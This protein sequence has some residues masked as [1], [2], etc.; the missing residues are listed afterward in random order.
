MTQIYIS[1]VF[2][3][4]EINLFPMMTYQI[5]FKITYQV[6]T[7]WSGYWTYNYIITTQNADVM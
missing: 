6:E 2:S 1:K 3:N 7:S 4:V 5:Q